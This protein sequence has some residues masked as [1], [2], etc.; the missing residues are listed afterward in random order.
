[1]KVIITESQR[2]YISSLYN[3]DD[4]NMNSIVIKEWV[5][6]NNK[7]LILLD[8]LYDLETKVNLGNI[9][10]NFNNFKVFLLNIYETSQNLPEK[11]KESARETL[12]KLIIT[13]S[14]NTIQRKIIIN[15]LINE[16]DN[17]FKDLSNWIGD[18]GK[19]AYLGT[20][21]FVNK[22]Y[23]GAKK[24]IGNISLGEWSKVLDLIKKGTIYVARS[25]RS[26]MYH[27]VGLALDAILVATG[28]G[29][30]VQW[31]PWAII[32]ALDVYELST[33]DYEDKES[34]MWMRYLFLGVDILGMLTAGGVAKATKT[35]ITT[36][37][38]GVKTTKGVASAISKTPGLKSFMLKLSEI[39]GSA[40][41]K[42]TEAIAFLKSKFP[43]GA[44]FIEG[45]MGAFTK[46]V[47][48]LKNMINKFLNKPAVGAPKLTTAEKISAGTR[49]GAKST[50]I[51]YGTEKA[52]EKGVEMWSGRNLKAE[53][54]AK[55]SIDNYIKQGGSFDDF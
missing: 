51:Y 14:D 22:S 9:W 29:K 16:E 15:S 33:G 24:L 38:K 28:I 3:N 43:K 47:E 17:W 20:T 32:V 41:T 55:I 45:I 27:P 37:L 23:I 18:K 52:I 2:E 26:A 1:M 30:S 8:D 39:L 10:E 19:E 35:L 54:N 44:S 4:F 21:E 53:K 31:I 12:G 49:A 13:E 50:G 36:S 48:K 42:M 46:F 34:P 11:L 5:T 25:L 40:G 7:Y 6:P